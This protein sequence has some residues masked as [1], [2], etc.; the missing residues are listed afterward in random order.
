[1]AVEFGKLPTEQGIRFKE[2]DKSRVP[3]DL[4]AP[5]TDRHQAVKDYLLQRLSAAE[6]R[7]AQRYSRW[8]VNELQFQAYINLQEHEKLLRQIRQSKSMPEITSLVI[9]YSYSTIM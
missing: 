8:R 5:G 1:M 9:P 3:I 4:L 6:K 2:A 7:M